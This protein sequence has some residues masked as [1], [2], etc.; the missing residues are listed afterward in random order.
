VWRLQNRKDPDCL[1]FQK[2]M[3]EGHMRGV[4][5][6]KQGIYAVTPSGAFLAS[7]NAIDG[8][9]MAA[10]LQRALDKWK[11]MSKQERLLSED[12]GKSSPLIQRQE[13]NFPADGLALRVLSR[14]IGRTDLPDDWRGKAWNVDFAWFRKNEM[15]QLLPK[16][17]TKG[18]AI[19]WPAPLARRLARFALVDNVRGQTDAYA[20]KDVLEASIKT[21]VT[22]VAKGLVT[23]RFT[24]LTKASTSGQWHDDN[25]PAGSRGLGTKILGNAVYDPQR[26]RFTSFEMLAIGTR[27]GMT[28]FN[29]R[30]QDQKISPIGFALVLAED[31]PSNRVAPAHVFAYGW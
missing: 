8:K 17:L 28:R 27:W 11:S 23:L 19:E 30:E 22:K 7:T 14:D 26:G 21:E 24:G 18:A 6:T 2:Y 29:F 5:N 15:A 10:M 12:P 20:D 9:N 4:P 1:H 13:N 25:P 31:K 16:D 3:E